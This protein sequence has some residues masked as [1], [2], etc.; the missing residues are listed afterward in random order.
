LTVA[1]SHANATKTLARYNIAAVADSLT[2]ADQHVIATQHTN[3]AT[4]L[5]P[6]S[7]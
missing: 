3:A 2:V 4:S 7:H 1:D 6:P 5:T